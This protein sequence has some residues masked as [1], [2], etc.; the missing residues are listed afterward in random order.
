MRLKGGAKSDYEI[1]YARRRCDGTNW[2]S[3]YVILSMSVE[4]DGNIS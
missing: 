2:W 1:G 4:V 3:N